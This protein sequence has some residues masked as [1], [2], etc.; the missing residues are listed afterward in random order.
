VQVVENGRAAIKQCVTVFCRLHDH[1]RATVLTLP[2]EVRASLLA[3]G[4]FL[5][6]CPSSALRF[7]TEGP[8]LK[9]LPVT[10]PVPPVPVGSSR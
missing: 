9:V 5:S 1:P 2:S 3:T 4:R 7:S 6:I 8:V 10:L